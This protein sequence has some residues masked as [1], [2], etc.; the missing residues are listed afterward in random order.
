MQGKGNDA[1]IDGSRLVIEACACAGS[2][3]FVAY[4]I[5]PANWLYRY[6]RERFPIAM[7]ATDEITTLQWMSG[8]SATGKFPVTATSYPGYALM[9]E[10]LG[11]AVMMEL[12]MVVVLV[13]RLGPATGSATTGAQGDLLSVRGTTSGGAIIP[14]LCPSN[15]EDCWTLSAKA[16]EVAVKLRT[17]V[18]LLTSKEMMMTLRSF[19]ISKLPPIEPVAWKR[20]DGTEPYVPYAPREGMIPPFVPVGDPKHRVR[21]NASTHDASGLIRKDT[22]DAMANTIRL[23]EKVEKRVGEFTFYDLDEGDRK[24]VLVVSYDVTAEAARSAVFA[25]KAKGRDVSLLVLK[26]LLPTPPVIH[27][28]VDRY[29]HVVIPEE[30]RTGQLREL[31]FGSRTPK[32]VVGVNGIG[33]MI[34]PGEIIKGVERCLS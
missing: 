31:L 17:P 7:A 30:N 18:V 20:Y 15:F 9:V 23:G 6:A 8:F 21:L 12:P 10:S 2:E 29:E 5:S 25:L 24:E 32:R 13:Q 16:V 1:L 34:A 11:M 3:A 26:T 33:H 22:P 14:T 28:I 27:E 19:D 4:P